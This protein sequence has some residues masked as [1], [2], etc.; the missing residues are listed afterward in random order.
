MSL[1]IEATFEN[2]VFIPVVRPALADHERVRLIVE[3]IDIKSP[4]AEEIVEK[5][6]RQRIQITPDLAH[7]I[8]TSPEFLPEES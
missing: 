4:T 7:E 1:S 2:G 5:G 6:R 8:A 3:S